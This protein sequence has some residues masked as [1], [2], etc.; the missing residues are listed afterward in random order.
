MIISASRRTD[1]PAFYS[2]WFMNRVRAGFCLVPN[3]FNR[4]QVS[5]VPLSIEQVEGIVFWTRSPRPLLPHLS[6]LEDRGYRYYFLYTILGNPREIDPGSPPLQRSI[7]T[8]LE[9]SS[10]IGPQRVVWR[11]DPILL[12]SITDPE[13]HIKVYNHIAE[14][15]KGHTLKSVISVAHMYRKVQGRVRRLS[16]HGVKMLPTGDEII[17]PLLNALSDIAAANDMK[18]Q[19]CASEFN[20]PGISPGK[21]IDEEIFGSFGPKV[22]AEKDTCQR[23]HCGCAASK[24]IG[25]YESCPAGCVY[26][27]A[28]ASFERAKENHRNHKPDSLSL[29]EVPTG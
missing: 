22:E 1:I 15:L 9:L 4:T 8:F 11:Y 12:T 7:E 19:G 3:P 13:Y 2:E 14:A 27:Y 26:C 16:D 18:M 6:E 17:S 28:T 25:M 23:E 29:L 20:I 5:H 21:C 24:D 10:R